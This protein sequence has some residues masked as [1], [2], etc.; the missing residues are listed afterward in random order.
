MR[1]TGPLVQCSRGQSQSQSQ[2]E[3]SFFRNR[4]S[5]DK[6]LN[7][8]YISENIAIDILIYSG[9]KILCLYSDRA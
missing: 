6:V 7:R 2:F 9:C 5:S 4:M 1:E 3:L 8:L